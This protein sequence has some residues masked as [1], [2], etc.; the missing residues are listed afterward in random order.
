MVG[1]EA[2]QM[3]TQDFACPGDLSNDWQS[4]SPSREPLRSAKGSGSLNSAESELWP[5]EPFRRAMIG[6]KVVSRLRADLEIAVMADYIPAT[7]PSPTCCVAMQAFGG[8]WSN[9]SRPS[10]LWPVAWPDQLH[11]LEHRSAH[12][13]RAGHNEINTAGRRIRLPAMRLHRNARRGPG[14]K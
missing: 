6:A 7:T 2:L 10:C 14:L 13:F 1:R 8:Y 4:G 3:I 11:R 5:P 12:P 9:A